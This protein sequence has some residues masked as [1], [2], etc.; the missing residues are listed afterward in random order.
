MNIT[1]TVDTSGLQLPKAVSRGD[2]LA[3]EDSIKQLP[4][5]LGEDPFPLTHLFAPGMY[6]RKIHIPAGHVI[7]GKIHR[8]QHLNFVMKGRCMVATEYGKKEVKAGDV[9]VSEAGLKRAVYAVEDC[10]WVTVHH[11]PTD[12]QDLGEIQENVIVP[13]FEALDAEIENRRLT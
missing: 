5:S 1:Y 13:S 6:A 11:N 3:L 9:F 4:G 2:I 10:E 12:T 8:H 7:I